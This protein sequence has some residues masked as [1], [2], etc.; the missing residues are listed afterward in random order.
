VYYYIYDDFLGE[1]R[2]EKEVQKVEGRL[3][4]LGIAGKI[5]RLAL[6][7]NAEDMIRD[8]LRKGIETVVVVGNDE[9]V[10]KVVD[11][12]TQSGVAFGIIPI[13]PKNEIAR[14]LGIP[15][16]MP[17][18]DILSARIIETIDMG[19]VNGRR[20]ISGLSIPN[21]SGEITCDNRYRVYPKGEGSLEV[22]NLFKGSANDQGTISNPCDGKLETIIRTKGKGG[23]K[24][25]GRKKAY[26]SMIPLKAFAIRS[27]NPMTLYADGEK[28]EA[29]RFDI[30]VEP[31]A[32]RTITGRNRLFEA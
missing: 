30:N 2:F 1:K 20:F 27:D 7:R 25:F 22:W 28:M 9:T 13:G 3:T 29:T 15:E 23:L 8:E 12:I 10:R 31:K 21:F 5:A 6:F 11:V 24:V 17:A 26:E 4:D 32:L 14:L 19:S 16:G 18:C